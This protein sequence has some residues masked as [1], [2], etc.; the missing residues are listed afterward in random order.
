[1]NERGFTLLETILVMMVVSGM[2]LFP[3]MIIP[4][5]REQ[6]EI[7]QFLSKWE[8]QYHS[9]QQYAIFYDE[10]T[11]M[12]TL[13]DSDT[14]AFRVPTQSEHILEGDLILPSNM[15]LISSSV[16]Y[17]I[18]PKTGILSTIKA[19]KITSPTKT[20]LIKFQMGSGKYTIEKFER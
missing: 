12:V 9:I 14:I 7:N 20:I 13:P 5:I 17:R 4:Q 16:T 15:N 19:I 8:T 10:F 11:T 3:I 6:T 2:V 18:K 1:M